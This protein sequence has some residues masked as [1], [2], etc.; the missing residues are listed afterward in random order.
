MGQVAGHP[1]APSRFLKAAAC[2]KSAIGRVVEYS[3]RI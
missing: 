3:I 2:P 1:A